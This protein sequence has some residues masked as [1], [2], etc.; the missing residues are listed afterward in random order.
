MNAPFGGVSVDLKDMSR[1]L[2]VHLEDFDCIVEP[3]VTHK[4]LNDWVPAYKG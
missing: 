2:A 1:V 4:Q 3:G